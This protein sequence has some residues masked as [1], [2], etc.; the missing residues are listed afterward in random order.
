MRERCRR[1]FPDVPPANLMNG[2]VSFVMPEWGPPI[3]GKV[4]ESWVREHGGRS[5]RV[6]VTT[7]RKS[8]FDRIVATAPDVG[9]VLNLLSAFWFERTSHIIP[10]HMID[11]PHPNVLIAEQVD[12]TLPVEL[13]LRRYMAKSSTSTSV[14]VNYVDLGRRNIYGVD[15]PDGLRANEAFPETLGKSGVIVT[16][17][18]K[19]G[20]GEHD[21]ELKDEQAR[22][23]VDAR[24]GAG[25]W[26]KAKRGCLDVFL[27][28]ADWLEKQGIVLVDTKIEM[29]IKD[30]RIM[31]IDELFTPDS[32]R[33]WLKS[34]Y[35]QRL[36]AGQNP[37]TFDKELLRGVLVQK[38][39]TGEG[40]VPVLEQEA[41]ER[42]SV[43]YREIFHRI[44]SSEYVKG[45]S[46]SPTTAT[47]IRASLVDYFGLA[48]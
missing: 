48:A 23:I 26:D 18:T 2:L 22:S 36:R 27:C 43:V 31:I 21:Q 8:A 32:S 20:E 10:N 42:L 25:T 37:E 29:G 19:A 28:A 11:V 3:R 1:L 40:P 34:T 5:V 24:C 33:F 12:I 35:Q 39:F 16:P 46:L 45:R 13:V 38:G 14:Y 47:A 4:R 17:T 41:I 7:D 15:F 6:M 44:T 30:G 9:R